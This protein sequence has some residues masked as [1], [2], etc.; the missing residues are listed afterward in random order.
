MA[1]VSLNIDIVMEFGPE[2]EA[3]IREQIYRHAGQMAR[4]LQDA[5]NL[6]MIMNGCPCGEPVSEKS[7]STLGEDQQDD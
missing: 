1:T 7:G 2:D 5:V 3:T 6:A 4:T